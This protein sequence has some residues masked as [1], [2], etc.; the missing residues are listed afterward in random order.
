MAS[1]L[2]AV[3]VN[4]RL[5]IEGG[6]LGKSLRVTADAVERERAGTRDGSGP[7]GHAGRNGHRRGATIGHNGRAPLGQD[8]N[9][10]AGRGDLGRRGQIGA[11]HKGTDVVLHVVAGQAHA[12]RHRFGRTGGAGRNANGAGRHF[13]F[14]ACVAQRGDADVAFCCD[15]F[16][17]VNRS[18]G[19]GR[20]LVHRDH[21]GH[22]DGFAVR[23]G[24]DIQCQGR[25][26]DERL[27]LSVRIG[28]HAQATRQIERRVDDAG[29]GA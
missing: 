27:N 2:V 11:A 7:T 9:V 16:R 13:G 18:L 8:L 22:A 4:L 3:F 1:G 28:R 24:A 6:P 19:E 25:V 14:D 17:L 29:C 10:A 26:D 12:H 15:C 21:G 5:R 23:L 20:D